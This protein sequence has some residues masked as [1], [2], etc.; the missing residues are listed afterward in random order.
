MWS[1]VNSNLG[2]AG[3]LRDVGEEVAIKTGTAEFGALNSKG[4]Y[5]HTHAWITGFFPFEDPK[6]SFTIFFEDGGLSFDALPHARKVLTWLIAN[7][8]S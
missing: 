5:E 6:Y 1:T 8:Y 4:E 2:S 3:I 7:G